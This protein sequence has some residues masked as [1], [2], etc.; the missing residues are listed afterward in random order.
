MMEVGYVTIRATFVGIQRTAISSRTSQSVL[1]MRNDWMILYEYKTSLVLPKKQQSTNLWGTDTECMVIH[2][3]NKSLMWRNA[4]MWS[5]WWWFTDTEY[6]DTEEVHWCRVYCD[7][8]LQRK[9]ADTEHI[10]I[11]WCGASTLIQR[12]TM[13]QILMLIWRS[14]WRSTLIQEVADT[15]DYTDTNYVVMED[16]YTDTNY[17][18]TKKDCWGGC[19]WYGGH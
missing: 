11:H 15:E 5:T 16:Y 9:Y 12:S 19:C 17:A 4:L 1:S 13:I 14:F 7:S 8:L 2:S 3:Y 6:T 18:D 10:V